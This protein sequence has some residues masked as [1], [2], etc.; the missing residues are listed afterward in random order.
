[1]SPND[2]LFSAPKQKKKSKQIQNFI[3]RKKREG[4]IRKSL[5]RTI[6]V[7]KHMKIQKNLNSLNKFVKK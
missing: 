7:D 4:I 3:E 1:M 5:E 6:E 2:D